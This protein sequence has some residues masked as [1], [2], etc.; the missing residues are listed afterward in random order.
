MKK[1]YYKISVHIK[2]AINFAKTGSKLAINLQKL[3]ID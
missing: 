3:D 1:F 2:L